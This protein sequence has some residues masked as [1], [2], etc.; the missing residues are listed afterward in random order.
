MKSIVPFFA[1]GSLIDCLGTTIE[2][3]VVLKIFYQATKAVGH[4]HAQSPPI[5]HRDIKVG[6]SV[7]CAN[8]GISNLRDSISFFFCF[9][10]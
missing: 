7:P 5:V 1:G 6:V 9:L 8:H 2:P 4:M 10:D 3:D